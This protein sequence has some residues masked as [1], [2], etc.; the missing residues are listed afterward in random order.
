MYN[1]TPDI[2]GKRVKQAVFQAS[3]LLCSVGVSGDKTTAKYAASLQKPNGYT[4]IPPWEAKARL[5]SVPVTKLCGIATGIGN[6]LAKYGVYTCGDMQKMPISILSKR[7]GNPGRRIWHMCQGTDPSPVTSHV[8]EA[9]TMG[10]GKVM[11]PRTTDEKVILTYFMHM[12][13][14]LAARLRR[15]D[16]QAQRFFIGLRHR[17]LGWISDK[18]R[19]AY[20]TD[21]GRIIYQL[22]KQLLITHW[23]GEPVDQVQVT[24]LDLKPINQQ[25]DFFIK[26][27]LERE[28]LQRSTGKFAQSDQQRVQGQN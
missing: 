21:D 26:H 24:A 1:T 17:Q 12:S 19:T 10:H 16:R 4:V 13:E 22:C 28:K 8:A 7:F 18:L 23:H 11:P 27:E 9:K 25:L 2:I 20:P 3:N 6:F 15:H 5:A 14:K